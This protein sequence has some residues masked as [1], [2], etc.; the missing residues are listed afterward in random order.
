MLQVF[1][2][3]PVAREVFRQDALPASAR[4]YSRDTITLGWEERLRA[5]GRRRSDAGLE[6]GTTLARGVAL[7]G[8]DCLVIDEASTVVVVIERAEPV[9]VVTPA[10]ASQWALFAY[11]IGNSHQPVM[12]TDSA[13]VCA[14]V[15]GMEQVL[16]YHAIPFTRAVRPFT[17]VGLADGSLAHRHQ[18]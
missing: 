11:H 10:S 1:K 2:P 14:D 6:F 17:P 16:Q 5:R 8:G 15:P 3:L 12:I 13:I 18:P 7:H 4:S 9:F